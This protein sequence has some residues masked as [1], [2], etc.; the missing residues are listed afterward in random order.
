MGALLIVNV[1]V[2]VA[3][4][5][6][7]RIQITSRE[8]FAN[9]TEYGTAG[10][11]EKIRGTAFFE[12]DPADNRNKVVFDLENTPRNARGMVEF[13]A[14]MYILK[15]VDMS[16]SNGALF[17]DVPNRGNK[18]VLGF[19]ND[20]P[21]AANANNPTTAL[22]AGNG[23]LFRQ[24]YTLIWVGWS[25]G[26]IAGG[27]RLSAQFPI[28]MQ[29]G[30]PITG[31][32]LTVYW[33]AEFGGARPFTLPLTGFATFKS[34]E[35]VSTNQ[36]AAQAELRVRPTDSPRPSGPAIPEGT[37]I[38]ASQWSFARCPNGPPGT[39]SNTDICLVGG[40][41]NNQTYE[42]VY[43]ATGSPISG[44]GYITT[45]DFASF[46]RRATVDDAGSP[47]PAAGISR[48]LCHGFSIS[49]QYLRDFVYQGFNE[50]EQGQKVCDGMFVHSAGAQKSSLNYRFTSDPN[51]TPF[52]SQHAAR[53]APETNF[54]R[55]YTVRPDP[56]T[57][58][59]DGLLKRPAT[60]PKIMHVNS[61]TEYW[62]RRAS[63]L[64]TDEAGKADLVESPDVRRYLI[65]GTQHSTASGALPNFSVAN[66]QCQQLSDSFH[67]GS[68]LRALVTA[69]DAWVR[70]GAEPP[71]S[72]VPTIADRTLVDSDQTSTGFPVIPDVTYNGLLNGSGDRDFGARVTNN[73]GIIDNLRAPILSTHRLLVPK[74]DRVGN[75]MA[76]I[77]HPFV[78][79]PVATLTGWSLRRPEFTDGDLCDAAGMMIPLRRTKVERTTAGD[80]RPSL[81]ELYTD[82]AGYV[83]KIT[84]AA[85]TLKD[86]GFLLQQDVDVAIQEAAAAPI[87]NA[88]TDGAGFAVNDLAPGSIVSVFGTSLAGAVL[89][90]APG[91]ALPTTLFDAA[92]TLNGISAPLYYVSPTQIDAQVPLELKPGAVT[93]QVS[94][95]LTTSAPQVVNL[96]SAAPAILTV[97]QQGTGA[98]LIFHAGDSRLVSANAPASAGETLVIYCSGLGALKSPL[99]SGDLAPNPAPETVNR[100]E[101]TIGGANAE[102]IL[103]SAA[104]GYAGVYQVKVQVPPGSSKGA[105]VAV[106]L[107][108]GGISSNT[109]TVAIE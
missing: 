7:T 91:S 72:Q 109:V 38:P 24:G 99:K 73:S 97:N 58:Q 68:V 41:Q 15:P 86:A 26:I 12:V 19:F 36:T 46:L 69:L 9:G 32:V 107:T 48:I 27:D 92:V 105:T 35:A 55:T 77:R 104:T 76:G 30:Q 34:Y 71:A 89:Q 103:S 28:A 16:K 57:G 61:S 101:V 60:D 25:S 106:R 39:P 87:V 85:Q 11:Y 5:R 82:Q 51:S 80:S 66:R 63:L 2:F 37:L 67:R 100:P 74:V 79:A 84:A 31:S 65:S 47:N 50:D 102:L 54:P 40:F 83:A 43:Q 96:M 13:S 14:D 59:M 53:G 10:A 4:A 1:P 70:T 44:L 56:L 29:D 93:I 23:F 52:R 81:E 33:D 49:G 88:I 21:P 42:L 62:E 90:A 45:R 8:P 75:D 18:T 94:R 108:I 17:V 20:A 64:D 6:V 22:D 95:N 3:E 98:G 78:E